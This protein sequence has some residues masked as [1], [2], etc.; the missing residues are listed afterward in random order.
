M[1][2]DG[3]SV[4]TLSTHLL[5]PHVDTAQLA[6]AEGRRAL[7]NP[8]ASSTRFSFAQGPRTPRMSKVKL[9]TR[10][11]R[12]TH[13]PMACL[14]ALSSTVRSVCF[15]TGRTRSRWPSY[16]APCPAGSHKA[17]ARLHSHEARARLRSTADPRRVSGARLRCARRVGGERS[18]CAPSAR[19]SQPGGERTTHQVLVGAQGTRRWREH[20]EEWS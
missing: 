13:P 11:S 1:P 14:C 18:R 3:C 19:F 17:Q 5:N 7:G 8:Y 16:R 6:R 12:T 4:H 20:P 10:P 2:R 15:V 9:A